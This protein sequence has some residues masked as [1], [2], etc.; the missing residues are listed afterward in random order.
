MEI[1]DIDFKQ[2]EQ[3]I[4]EIFPG[5]T[6]YVRDVNLSPVCAEKYEP[7]MI[8]MERG[9][10][11]ASNRVMGM[12]TMHRFAI[13]SNHMAD[14][15]PYEHDTNWGLFVAQS[16]THFKILDVYESQGRTQITLLHLPDDERWKIFE[17]VK[18]SLENQI[19]EMSRQRF[20][21]KS[22]M[23]PIPE[24]TSEG[25]LRRCSRPLGMDDQG[26]LFDLE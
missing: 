23:D 3:V 14:F 24:L 25:W 13:L 7:D 18:I 11:D 26:N 8:I 2:M 6:M 10:T 1:Q 5:L 9:F 22:M 15:R 16:G 12:V 21:A 19:V 20:E 4:N 17:N